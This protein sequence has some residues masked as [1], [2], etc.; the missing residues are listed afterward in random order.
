MRCYQS[1][2]CHYLLS[3]WGV[4]TKGTTDRSKTVQGK[5]CKQARGRSKESQ[6]GG[7]ESLE[8]TRDGK[9]DLSHR[10]KHPDLN[11]IHSP[12]CLIP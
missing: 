11:Y 4:N 3:G 7:G 6:N 1:S 12:Q 5:L 10:S 9:L 8:K 2:R